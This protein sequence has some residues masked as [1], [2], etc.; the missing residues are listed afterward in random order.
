MRRAFLTALVTVLAASCTTDP[1]S[2]LEKATPVLSPSQVADLQKN[3]K[4]PEELGIRMQLTGETAGFGNVNVIDAHENVTVPMVEIPTDQPRQAGGHYRAP[5]VFATVNG[6]PDV[7]VTLDSG[8]NLNLFGYTLARSLGIPM[9]AGLKPITGH[10]IGGSV[11][12]YAA[13]LPEMQI[14]SIQFH[15]MV[16][17]I[18]PDEQV[19]GMTHSF[20]GDKQVML[21]GVNA[22]RGLSYLTID[23]LRGNVIFGAREGYLPDDTLKFM[24]AVPLHWVGRLPAVDIS[25]DTHEAVTCILDT[26]GD[27]GMLLPR[28]RAN[29]WGYWIP[30]KGPLTIPGGVG[31]ASLATSYQVKVVKLGEATLARIPARTGLIGPEVGGGNVFLGDVVLRRYR[32]TFDFRRDTLWLE[33]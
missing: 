21:L 22:L 5:V 18:G 10:G 3:A 33:K 9:I 20:W 23:N 7:P 25:V 8:S 15:R 29:E 27:Y 31:G 26:G 1:Y 12:N 32:V 16:T 11:D 17:L 30:G 13:I 4:T 28:V 2:Q 24:T 19:L 6:K 14:G